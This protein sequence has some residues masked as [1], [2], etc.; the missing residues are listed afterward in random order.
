L[1]R[2]LDR[3]RYTPCLTNGTW[4]GKIQ[5]KQLQSKVYSNFYYELFIQKETLKGA[6]ALRGDSKKAGKNR[7]GH[8]PPPAIS[9]KRGPGPRSLILVNFVWF[10]IQIILI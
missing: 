10:H 3:Y 2:D 4:Y 5:S 1:E 9:I 6:L 7:I 8:V